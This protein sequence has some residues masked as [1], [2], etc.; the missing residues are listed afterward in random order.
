LLKR[1]ARLPA[2][3]GSTALSRLSLA[4]RALNS[5]VLDAIHLSLQRAC[6][7]KYI[8][9]TRGYALHAFHVSSVIKRLGDV[10]PAL[11]LNWEGPPPDKNPDFLSFRRAFY[12]ITT[13]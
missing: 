7:H 4:V 8:N 6:A 1:G 5:A 9:Q 12:N 11:Y 3:A 10:L 2:I 13:G